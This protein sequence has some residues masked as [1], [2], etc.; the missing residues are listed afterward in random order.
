MVEITGWNDQPCDNFNEKQIYAFAD[1]K[2]D[3][4]PG[5]VIHNMPAS[6]IP[7]P[8][9][10][11]RTADGDVCNLKSNGKWHWVGEEGDIDV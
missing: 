8:G 5:M 6:W 4:G 10:M 7:Q 1:E 3:V 11:I 2:S 9:S